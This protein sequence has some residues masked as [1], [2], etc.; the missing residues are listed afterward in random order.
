ML[1][2]VTRELHSYTIDDFLVCFRRYGVAAPDFL[3]P[4]TYEALFAN[5]LAPIG[6]YVFTDLDRLSSYEID[7]A[8]EIAKAL[9]AVPGAAILNW[10]N[11]ILGRYARID[12]LCL[13][14]I[15]Y[16]TLDPRGAELLFQIIT[17]REERASIACAS[18]APSPNGATPSPTRDSPPQWWTGSPSTPTSS[19]PAPAATGSPAAEAR[20]E[21]PTPNQTQGGAKS[22]QHSGAKSTCHSHAT[23]RS[24]SASS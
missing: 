18:N 19:K 5:K 1:Y 11:R 7:A 9:S 23:V 16:L 22:G 4:I 15:G 14:Q 17:A 21:P 12:L 10:P 13:D 3:R 24:S 8:A 2:Y 20:K 6:N